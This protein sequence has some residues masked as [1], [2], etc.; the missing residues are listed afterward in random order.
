MSIAI[1]VHE[2]ITERDG[3][4]YEDW[5]FTLDSKSKARVRVRLEWVSLGNFGVH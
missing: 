3:S 4:P 2:Y 1:W 5:L